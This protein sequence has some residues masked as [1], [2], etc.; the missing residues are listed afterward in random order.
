MDNGDAFSTKKY[1]YYFFAACFSPP[2]AGLYRYAEAGGA[3][4][5]RWRFP[6]Q[7]ATG[8]EWQGEKRAD[9]HFLVC[10]SVLLA[11]TQEF[12]DGFLVIILKAT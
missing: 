11:L 7:G 1:H 12:M 8:T 5:D 9:Y 6:L 3:D 10:Y 2:L 4:T